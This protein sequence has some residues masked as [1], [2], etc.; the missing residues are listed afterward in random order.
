M[1]YHIL[2]VDF[3]LEPCFLVTPAMPRLVSSVKDAAN[4]L[5][6]SGAALRSNCGMAGA[7]TLSSGQHKGSG[8][9]LKVAIKDVSNMC[10]NIMQ[11]GLVCI[12]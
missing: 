4:A 6:A 11:E 9:T 12:N 5:K 2:P 1:V 8:T 7:K 10:Q 3:I